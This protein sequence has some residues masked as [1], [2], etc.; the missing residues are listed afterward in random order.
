MWSSMIFPV[1]WCPAVRTLVSSCS[2]QL[3]SSCPAV[4]QCPAV[5]PG[6]QL[7]P[8]VSNYSP[9]TGVACVSTPWQI[10]F[11]VEKFPI[12]ICQ[13]LHSP[14]TCLFCYTLQRKNA[15]NLKQLFPEKEYRGPSP[16][17]FHI[18]VSVSELYIPTMELP[19][20]LEEICGPILGL[21]K[22]LT[23]TWM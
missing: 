7:F 14:Y 15:E 12:V 13:C 19:F 1:P 17:N 8:L 10:R 21:Y 20:L 23:D 11:G 2:V 5:P 9:G 3:L 22:S 18:H 16:P 4:S 6:V